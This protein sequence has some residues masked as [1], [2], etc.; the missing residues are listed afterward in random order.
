MAVFKCKMCGGDLKVIDEANHLA[1]CESCGTKQTLPNEDDERKANQFNRANHYRRSN[2]FDRAAEAYAKILDN[3]PGEAEAYWGTVL[4][5]YGIEYVEDKKTMRRI[6]TCHR[7]LTRSILQDPDYQQALACAKPLAKLQYEEEAKEIDRLQKEILALASREDPF[8][9]FISYKETD[10]RSGQRTPDSV[11]GQDIYNALTKEGYKVFF[12]RITL[13]SRLGQEYEPIIYAALRSSKVMIAIGTKP[14]YFESPWVRN[15]WNRYLGMIEEEPGEKTLIPV[16]RDMD[17]YD[18]PEEF[19]HLQGLNAA[20][21]GFLQDLVHGV[22]KLVKS[23]GSA[24]AASGSAP[25][26]ERA[27]LFL[28][29]G[30]FANAASYSQRYLDTAPKDYRGYVTALMAEFHCRQEIQLGQLSQDYTQKPNYQNALR[31]APPSKKAQLTAWAESAV[32][33]LKEKNY[34]EGLRAAHG[35]EN[36]ACESGGIT[37]WEAAAR[38]YEQLGLDDAA[39][40]CRQQAYDLRLQEA[41]K[42]EE[43]AWE[44]NDPQDW[45]AA[46]TQYES[47]ERREE[48]KICRIQALKPKEEE[49]KKKS[50]INVWRDLCQKYQAIQ[51]NDEAEACR[52][53][54]KELEDKVR[55]LHA[56]MSAFKT[57][58]RRYSNIVTG[59]MIVVA[60]I[61]LISQP[62]YTTQF[63]NSDEHGFIPTLLV[64]YRP[65][66]VLSVLAGVF[67]HLTNDAS[68]VLFVLLSVILLLLDTAIIASTP[69]GGNFFAGL[70]VAVGMSVPGIPI[71]IVLLVLSGL[72]GNVLAF[73]HIQKRKKLLKTAQEI[74]YKDNTTPLQLYTVFLR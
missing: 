69:G 51:A 1:Q 13:E 23:G 55:S 62:Q 42:L 40:K 71:C 29:N 72:L 17:P 11:L 45:E 33:N 56:D 26:L 14:E 9:I 35:L 37:D 65:I 7:T 43:K 25:L 60:I 34:Q 52:T 63:I 68:R 8:D 16:Y 46:A 12:S 58:E 6:P 73:A 15:E 49:A 66:F 39:Q 54:E 2:E 10:E 3:D 18:M 20:N 44:T 38:A 24:P 74:H 50:E 21:I 70:L 22:E 4:C 59:I 36:K 19:A 47:V 48:A 67:R 32:Q 28:E 57:R 61:L 5:R 31:F 53:A 64:F 30:D 41:K 27:Q